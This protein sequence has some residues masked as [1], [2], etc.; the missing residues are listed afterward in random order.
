MQNAWIGHH[1]IKAGDQGVTLC[2]TIHVSEFKEGK[3]PPGACTEPDE[4][5]EVVGDAGGGEVCAG[6]HYRQ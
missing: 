1:E 6:Q 3:G 5:W 4:G 2:N